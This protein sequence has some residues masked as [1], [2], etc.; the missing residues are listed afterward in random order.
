MIYP[1]SQTTLW[2]SYQNA[3]AAFS[4]IIFENQNI[5]WAVSSCKN[6]SDKI[7]FFHVRFH[8]IIV[9]V[10]YFGRFKGQGVAKNTISDFQH[11]NKSTEIVFTI[12][13]MAIYPL[14]FISI[15]YFSIFN[16]TQIENIVASSEQKRTRFSTIIQTDLKCKEFYHI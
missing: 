7:E 8:Y 2:C 14:L 5:R 3:K 13:T 4:N 1:D 9:I 6:C 15:F 11:S 12:N 16:V 10:V